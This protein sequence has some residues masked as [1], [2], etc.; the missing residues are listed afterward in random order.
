MVWLFEKPET[1]SGQPVDDISLADDSPHAAVAQWAAELTTEEVKR[2]DAC[3]MRALPLKVQQCGKLRMRRV[4]DASGDEESVPFSH[5]CLATS[6]DFAKACA[7]ELAPD[8]R[9]FKAPDA[10]VYFCAMCLVRVVSGAAKA[11]PNGRELV[12]TFPFVYRDQLNPLT[13]WVLMNSNGQANYIVRQELGAALD[14]PK[15]G[16][17][18]LGASLREGLPEQ[19][20]CE[21]DEAVHKQLDQVHLQAT[22]QCGSAS[23]GTD[24]AA[25][26]RAALAQLS[27]KQRSQALFFD[28][29]ELVTRTIDNL[30]SL[31]FGG[32][33]L[34]GAHKEKIKDLP[35]LASLEIEVNSTTGR[36]GMFIREDILQDCEAFWAHLER[37]CPKP[38][39]GKLR[40]R[41][42]REEWLGL[43]GQSARDPQ[44]LQ[45][46]VAQLVE[47]RLWELADHVQPRG[48][49]PEPVVR[50]KASPHGRRQRCRRKTKA[51]TP[52]AFEA[53]AGC[54]LADSVEAEDSTETPMAAEMGPALPPTADADTEGLGSPEACRS[55]SADDNLDSAAPSSSG[56]PSRG[57][58]SGSTASLTEQAPC[59][60]DLGRPE[61]FE[62]AIP[63]GSTGA[64][65]LPA[66][67][68][69]AS[70]TTGADRGDD[71]L[72]PVHAGARTDCD[73]QLLDPV[74]RAQQHP[75]GQSEASAPADLETGVLGGQLD[76]TAES[77]AMEAAVTPSTWPTSDVIDQT[78]RPSSGS[79]SLLMLAFS[80]EFKLWSN[81]SELHGLKQAS[82]TASASTC[83]EPD[84]CYSVE[85]N[86]EA[87]DLPWHNTWIPDEAKSHGVCAGAGA[88]PR[89]QEARLDHCFSP[90]LELD[91]Y[92]GPV[93]SP[94]KVFEGGMA[95]TEPLMRPPPGLELDEY[96]VPV[97]SP[98]KVFEG[99]VAESEP[100]MRP[101]PGLEL[102][103]E[104]LIQRLVQRNIELEAQLLHQWRR[105][106][107][108]SRWS[109]LQRKVVGPR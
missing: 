43:L 3:G 106:E 46:R 29:V 54:R 72:Q 17:A 27:T 104:V 101:P 59:P 15:E 107:L 32:P 4:G 55:P 18:N 20:T 57:C 9:E 19:E 108:R 93:G 67:P 38:F 5:V 91:E 33:C 100:L 62:H 70:G 77:G 13:N 23:K 35:W 2:L 96:G 68:C 39:S 51:C 8:I 63:D 105:P 50:I 87:E 75:W 102:D 83:S 22:A 71:A 45:Q 76:G 47:Q 37:S 24:D 97:V 21:Q 84:F 34:T 6:F 95:E 99:G 11:D 90:G 48:A 81:E 58:L 7:L 52:A 31:T 49:L 56:P 85:C 16:T 73:S 103:K 98:G 36:L 1:A 53:G 10:Q 94:G 41:R 86:S 64:P 61:V 74:S 14:A 82:T 40:R 42:A 88:H 28:D 30:K 44:R 69:G 60:R 65:A 89:S 79:A 109:A 78:A 25:A 12:L 26:I 92:C 66:G 80:E